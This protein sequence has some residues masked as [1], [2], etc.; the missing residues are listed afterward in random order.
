MEK[1]PNTVIVTR[2][3][4]LVMYIREIGL[5]RPDEEPKVITHATPEDVTGNHVI[6]VLPHH[7]SCLA[8]SLTEVPLRMPPV[9]RGK[10]LSLPQ[11]REFAGK[12]AKYIVYKVDL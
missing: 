9:F 10:E 6:G 12:P 8:A 11:V 5:I 4:A 2:H 7:L 1:T 3:P